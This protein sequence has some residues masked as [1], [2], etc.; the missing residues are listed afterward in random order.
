[1]WL[2]VVV[3]L[4]IS[5]NQVCPQAVYKVGCYALPLF[6]AP[7]NERNTDLSF[8]HS[9]PPTS[10]GV[11]PAARKTRSWVNLGYKGNA[12]RATMHHLH[13]QMNFSSM[14]NLASFDSV[15]P[16]DPR[17]AFRLPPV[18]R[19]VTNTAVCDVIMYRFRRQTEV[20]KRTVT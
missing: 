12:W 10:S 7:M 19:S 16:T 13:F 20:S 18:L 4:V 5:E 3:L 1:M 2:W 17:P 11:R 9:E 15:G 8:Y 6:P 14:K